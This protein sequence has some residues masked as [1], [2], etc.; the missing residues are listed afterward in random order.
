MNSSRREPRSRASAG[1]SAAPNAFGNGAETAAV[2]PR[3][4]ID[5]SQARRV[6]AV[7]FLR[8]ESIPIN[9]DHTFPA[10][11]ES[12]AGYGPIA[13][14]EGPNSLPSKRH[15]SLHLSFSQS[16]IAP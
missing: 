2:A 12:F 13:P 1:A 10:R 8:V 7:P 14:H 3:Q 4:A 5:S 16:A 9:F 11:V 6:S 15:N